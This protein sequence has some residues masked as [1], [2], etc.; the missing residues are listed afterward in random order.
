M[1]GES[2]VLS[3]LAAA[4]EDAEAIGISEGLS[5][6]ADKGIGDPYGRGQKSPDSC[7]RICL[8]R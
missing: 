3:D 6:K 8:L 7:G 1:V 2:R 4:F 5:A